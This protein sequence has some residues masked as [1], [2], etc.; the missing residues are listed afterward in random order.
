MNSLQKNIILWFTLGLTFFLLPLV[1][2]SNIR[3]EKEKL[4]V[5]LES[6]NYTTAKLYSTKSDGHEYEKNILIESIAAG[7]KKQVKV[8][9]GL[10]MVEFY[11]SEDTSNTSVEYPISIDTLITTP[12][13]TF[14]KTKLSEIADSEKDLITN[15]VDIKKLSPN[16]EIG[17]IV[18][19]GKGNIAGLELKSKNNTIDNKKAIISKQGSK[20]SL[21][22][23]PDIILQKRDF[24]DLPLPLLREV[25]NIRVEK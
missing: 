24:P 21:V 11:E 13:L 14:N 23:G 5:T 15:S 18:M 20:W 25:N 10:Y 12:E 7:E 4:T 19:Y 1:I 16:Y 9:T 8:V 3:E 22:A 2:I 6:K 17:K